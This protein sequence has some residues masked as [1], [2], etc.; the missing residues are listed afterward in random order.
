MASDS[1]PQPP[2]E[3][4]KPSSP[5]ENTTLTDCDNDY[6]R[7]RSLLLGDEFE[8]VLKQ[9]LQDRSGIER[10]SAIISEAI[11]LRSAQDDSMGKTL[12]PLV[13]TA[14]E[15]SIERN[16]SRITDVIFPILGPAIRK[17]VAAALSNMV[18]TLNTL[19]EQ[20]LSPRALS[21]RI[22]AWRSGMTYAQYVIARTVLYRVEQVFLIHRDTGLLIHSIAAE[23]IT[24]E[25]PDL[26][27]AMLTAISDFVSDSFVNASADSLD[28]IRVG[29]LS[30]LIA[31]GP[32]AVLALAIQGTPTDDVRS[33]LDACCEDIHRVF[34]SLLKEFNGDRDSLLS[35][36]PYLQ[37][38]LLSQSKDDLPEKGRPWFGL[39]IVGLVVIGVMIKSISWF[40]I[41]RDVNSFTHF[42]SQLPGFVLIREEL[43][44][45]QLSVHVLQ[46]NGRP[47]LTDSF[48]AEQ[49]K[50][51]DI[52]VEAT[53][54]HIGELPNNDPTANELR[55]KI[56]DS[57]NKTALYFQPK[58]DVFTE[59]SLAAL[60]DLM[61]LIARLRE[62]IK[63]DQTMDIQ[64]MVLGFADPTGSRSVNEKV[65]QLRADRV[66]ELLMENGMADDAVIAW[67]VGSRDLKH[68]PASEQRRVQLFVKAYRINRENI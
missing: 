53:P 6:L 42:I 43:Q 28:G 13:N 62:S 3:S 38:C 34:N 61:G 36:D 17:A 10:V 14:I 55:E 39:I 46:E 50:Y 4:P 9:Q 7:L 52:H 54:I 19:L 30:V 31:A 35:V 59:H 2:C 65:S 20:S 49:Y 23:G 26:V 22:N 1:T 57:I 45:N 5:S 66:R 8:D 32:S 33:Q 21:W 60:S 63:Q 51:I 18:Q 40:L 27:S 41:E 16:P 11:A 64:V 37:Q 48:S 24:A 58:S 44:G 29:E 67:G 56:I 47:P 68:V 15:R 25:D 12:A